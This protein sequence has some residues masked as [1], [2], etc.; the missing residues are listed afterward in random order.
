MYMLVDK[1][2]RQRDN[3]KCLHLAAGMEV[4]LHLLHHKVIP[5]A[6][7]AALPTSA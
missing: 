3:Q 7:V 5:H 6:A 2:K 1:D 4:A